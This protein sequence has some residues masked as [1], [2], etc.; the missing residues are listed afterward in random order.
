MSQASRC[1]GGPGL[2]GTLE[3][4]D[5]GNKKKTRPSGMCLVGA[6]RPHTL[7]RGS[8]CGCQLERRHVIGSVVRPAPCLFPCTLAPYACRESDAGGSCVSLQKPFRQRLWGWD[9]RPAPAGFSCASCIQAGKP[10]IARSAT[11]DS[12]TTSP[13]RPGRSTRDR[14][15]F[16]S[17]PCALTVMP[18]PVSLPCAPR[19]VCL[20]GVCLCLSTF[21][22]CYHPLL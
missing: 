3:M 16:A 21:R 4:S 2:L 7:H 11:P 22:E 18:P 1:G 20:K 17:P 6:S 19:I 10:V 14:K 13:L 5:S 15:A 12:T 9:S 8:L